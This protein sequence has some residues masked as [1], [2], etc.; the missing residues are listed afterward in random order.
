M[1]KKRKRFLVLIIIIVIILVG[2]IIIFNLTKVNRKI[3]GEWVTP[4]GTIYKFEKN[5]VGVMITSSKDYNF[6]YKINNKE[7]IIDYEDEA[8]FDPTYEYEFSNDKLIVKGVNGTFT[9]SRK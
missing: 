6:K 7:L 5:N 8:A 9:F 4:G 2:T 1:R 3:L